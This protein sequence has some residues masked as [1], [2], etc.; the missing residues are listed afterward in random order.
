ML[1]YR[2]ID[3][4][5]LIKDVT[6]VA[7]VGGGGKTSLSEFFARAA[8]ASGRRVLITTTTKIWAQEPFAT[9]DRKG[10]KESLAAPFIRVGKSNEEGKL[11]GLTADE[12]RDIGAGFDLV[13]V[14]A[15]G[16]K[17]LPLK[18]PSHFEP[19]IPVFSEKVIVVA[20]LDGL[21][22]AVREKVFRWPLF[23][24]ASG[25]SG[26]DVV[27]PAVFSRLF[28]ADGLFKG[29]ET[30][31]ALI[32]LNKYDACR[33]RR[34]ALTMAARLGQGGRAVVVASICYSLFYGIGQS[35]E[36]LDG[37]I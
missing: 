1:Y 12:I 7:F 22:E 16:A 17:G 13:L 37:W 33:R 9:L 6:Y 19:V 31:K 26:D 10:W 34:D 14:E 35:S 15:D 5:R 25:V 29:V 11:T 2:K 30:D 4:Y 28:E 8:G 21:Y 3:P 24:E 18:Y 23:S 32:F 36:R 27:T 20:G